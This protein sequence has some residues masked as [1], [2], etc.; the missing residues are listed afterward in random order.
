MLILNSSI[1]ILYILTSG[2]MLLRKPNIV[3]FLPWIFGWAIGFP[4]LI[5]IEEGAFITE[6]GVWGHPNGATL[7]YAIYAYSALIVFYYFSDRIAPHIVRKSVHK[8]FLVATLPFMVAII[9]AI[10][11]NPNYARFNIFAINDILEKLLNYYNTAYAAIYFFCSIKEEIKWKRIAYFFAALGLE[12]IKGS[13]FG[14]LLNIFF[15]FIAGEVLASK[16][17]V[18]LKVKLYYLTVFVLVCF[19][20]LA[21]KAFALE[22]ALKTINRI[23]LQSHLFWGVVNL[24]TS[25]GGLVFAQDFFSHIMSLP[26]NRATTQYGLGALMYLFSG[27]LADQFIEDG[28]RFSGGYPSIFIYYFGINA[29][30]FVNI[31]MS[32]VI[33]AYIK[34]LLQITNAYNII[35]LIVFYKLS[36]LIVVDLYSAGELWNINGKSILMALV[37][38]SMF[39]ILK[40]THAIRQI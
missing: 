14:G 19:L 8:L 38:Y 18:D 35:V 22:D 28:V 20:A 10:L 21:Y 12:F 29:T 17:N 1:S 36:A 32:A 33:A 37:F 27:A 24:E 5:L 4:S 3:L 34:I 25:R 9:Y 15:V 11:Q 31:L 23:V 2:Y 6:Q 40:K 39:L 16:Q 26:E 13:E 7:I 30:T